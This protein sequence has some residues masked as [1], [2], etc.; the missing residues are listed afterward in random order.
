MLCWFCTNQILTDQLFYKIPEYVFSKIP[1]TRAVTQRAF[2]GSSAA[3]SVYKGCSGASHSGSARPALPLPAS[4]AASHLSNQDLLSCSAV[5]ARCPAPLLLFV[6]PL[7]SAASQ[8]ASLILWASIHLAQPHPHAL[9]LPASLAS[10]CFGSHS[11]PPPT[12]SCT[13]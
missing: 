1:L 4:P 10:L 6:D 12:S 5:P 7:V 13:F 3:G 2:K 11:S 9:H 8:L